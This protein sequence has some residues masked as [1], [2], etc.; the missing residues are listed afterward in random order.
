MLQIVMA[1]RIDDRRA[2]DRSRRIV[3]GT[4]QILECATMN[5]HVA[6]A[7]AQATMDELD[8][9]FTRRF[10]SVDH[11]ARFEPGIERNRQAGRP[12]R[13]GAAIPADTSHLVR[14]V[15]F[16]SMFVIVPGSIGVRMRVGVRRIGMFVLVIGVAVIVRVRVLDAVG[17]GVRVQMFVVHT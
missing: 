12:N 11:Q 7:Q 1:E 5:R 14:V 16:C 17:V 3:A 2:V 13:P 4:N 10:V 6:L 15:Y 9:N 8:Q